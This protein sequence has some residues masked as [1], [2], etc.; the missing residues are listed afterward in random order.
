[1]NQEQIAEQLLLP[2]WM[3]VD[4]DFKKKYK[5]D[6]W[7][8]FENFIKTSACND[9]LKTFFEKFKRLMPISWQHKYEK[10]VL[11]VIQSGF[12]EDALNY[13]RTESSYLVLLTRS[14]NNQRKEIFKKDENINS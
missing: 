13:M 2:L 6:S 14:L 12:D 9:S 11:D 1:M 3:C 4:E 8:I 7:G 5:A 10:Q